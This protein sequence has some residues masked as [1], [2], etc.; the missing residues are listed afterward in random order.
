MPACADRHRP[1]TA[2][3]PAR[4]RNQGSVSS[5]RATLFVASAPDARSSRRRVA[6]AGG[7]V[8]TRSPCH[9]V[10]PGGSG[11]PDRAGWWR[12]RAP[13]PRGRPA[14]HR[15]PDGT[16][17]TRRPT[18]CGRSGGP[19]TCCPGDLPIDSL[20]R[21]VQ[22]G[23]LRQLPGIGEKTAAAVAQ[24][25]AGE[26][27]D[28]LVDLEQGADEPVNER[29]SGGLPGSDGPTP[30][31]V[32]LRHALRGDC[33]THSTGPTAA[34][35]IEEMARGRPR[36]RP[37]V[38]GAHRPLAPADRR[39]RADRRT[40]CAPSSTRSPR[41]TTSWRRSG[42]SPG[43]RSTSSRTARSTRSPSLL[44]AARRRGRQRALEAADA[45]RRR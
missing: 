8:V 32:A 9:P 1:R 2:G 23:T 10:P 29:G 34:R 22:L 16:P 3:R 36:P 33:H 45:R 41:S 31:G 13:R 26:L 43:S 11:R 37:R 5:I 44:G 24:S 27:P 4:S 18:G 12:D 15:L 42:S 28:Y 19:P 38:P 14:P 40:G 20:Q 17:S 21:R 30:A 25:L 6:V 7:V 39:Q 35:P